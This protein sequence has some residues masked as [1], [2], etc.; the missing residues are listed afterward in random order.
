MSAATPV[1]TGRTGPKAAEARRGPA[2]NRAALGF[3]LP[4]GLLFTALFLL[5]IGYAVWQSLFRIERSGLGFGPARTVFAGIDNYTAALGDGSFVQGIGRVLLFG[6]VQVPVMLGLAL[7]LA[8]LIDA[9]G[10]RFRKFFRLAYF[11]PYAIPGVVATVLWAFLYLPGTSPLVSGLASIGIDVDFLSPDTVL[12]S[13]ANIVTW[14]WTGYNM[15]VILSALQAIPSELYEAADLDGAG[16]WRIAWHIKIPLVAPALVLT[17]I[18]SI[19]GTLQLFTEPMVLHSLA[20]TVSADYTPNMAAYNAAFGNNDYG[21]AAAIA[22]LLALATC[23]LSF[24]FLRLSVRI[25]GD[26]V[27]A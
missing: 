11:L 22:V 12:W 15:L 24:T 21:K 4:F 20:S 16:A 1:V 25:T 13:M 5:P 23:A 10:A 19:I 9:K 7:G 26:R 27:T 2:R 18:F 3:L 8:L 6:A 14:T 17:G